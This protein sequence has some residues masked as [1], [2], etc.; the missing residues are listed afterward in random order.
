[1]KTHIAIYLL[2]LLFCSCWQEDSSTCPGNG[3]EQAPYFMQVE[4]EETGGESYD[5]I[6]SIRF[7]VFTDLASTPRAE[8]NTLYNEEDFVSEEEVEAKSLKES[9]SEI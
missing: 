8:I 5:R 3:I 2:F 7:I 4:I 6:R 9:Q 1:M